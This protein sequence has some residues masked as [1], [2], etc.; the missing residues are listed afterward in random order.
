MT[1]NLS[2]VTV[3]T[4]SFLST[5]PHWLSIVIIA[6]LPVSELRGAIPV[7]LAPANVGGYA[8]SVPE[9]YILAVIGNM[10]PVIPLLLFL[11]PV[12]DFLRRWRIWDVFFTWL[13]TRTHRNHNE[14]FEKYGTLALTLFVAIPLPVT[15][16]WTG[17]AAAFVFGIKFRH[18]LLAIFAG[19]LIAG[20][21]VSVFT[22]TGISIF[23]LF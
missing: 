23:E 19:V 12:S 18:A 8:M 7:A 3:A 22:L 5:I 2:S 1:D 13:F 4:A 17:C 10:I 20:V 11:E 15:G 16:A 9:A 14:R 21:V 6:M